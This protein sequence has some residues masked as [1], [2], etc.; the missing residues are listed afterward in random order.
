MTINAVNPTD[1]HLLDPFPITA[2]LAQREKEKPR[3]PRQILV[4]FC[5][6]RFAPFKRGQTGTHSSGGEGWG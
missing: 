6:C 3:Q 2:A 1:S 4:D 5:F